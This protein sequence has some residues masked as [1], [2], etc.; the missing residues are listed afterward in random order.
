MNR[1][2]TLLI[3]FGF[4]MSLLPAAVCL[5]GGRASCCCAD[6]SD[7]ADA[8]AS[9]RLR[10]VAPCGCGCAEI[11]RA[12]DETGPRL[13]APARPEPPVPITGLLSP[14]AE[15]RPVLHAGME[16]SPVP[17]PVPAGPLSSRHLALRI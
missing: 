13:P 8:T 2:T 12:A 7:P 15:C 6:P 5:G 16:L 11:T 4:A 14:L 9:Q 10:L 1:V 3:L 17:P